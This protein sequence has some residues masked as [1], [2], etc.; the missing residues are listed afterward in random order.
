MT[1]TTNCVADKKPNRS[2]LSSSVSDLK[3]VLVFPRVQQIPSA[4]QLGESASSIPLGGAEQ[5]AVWFCCIFV[6]PEREAKLT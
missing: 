2:L 5:R 6:P 1:R 4:A 3:H